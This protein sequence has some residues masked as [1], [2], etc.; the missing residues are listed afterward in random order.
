MAAAYWLAPDWLYDSNYIE[1]VNYRRWVNPMFLKAE[2]WGRPMRANPCI[3]EEGIRKGMTPWVNKVL[4]PWF[5]DRIHETMKDVAGK[6]RISL[7]NEDVTHA[8]FYKTIYD[9]TLK[10]WYE[11][12]V[13]ALKNNKPQSVPFVKEIPPRHANR[14]A[15]EQF[16]DERQ[17][18]D[19]PAP[20]QTRSDRVRHMSK[21]EKQLRREEKE[22][23]RMT[24]VKREH[25]IDKA[26]GPPPGSASRP[27]HW[28]QLDAQRYGEAFANYITDAMKA[29][30]ADDIDATMSDDEIVALLFRAWRGKGGALLAHGND[31]SKQSTRRAMHQFVPRIR[32]EVDKYRPEG[33]GREAAAAQESELEAQLAAAERWRAEEDARERARERRA[34][35]ERMREPEPEPDAAPLGM[36]K[37]Y[38]PPPAG[39][40]KFRQAQGA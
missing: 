9:K 2:D 33:P 18:S 20:S 3:M 30:L 37:P 36:E 17:Y 5:R 21:S 11:Q 28:K 8:L 16:G 7:A 24:V 35:E 34:Y 23:K 26:L 25:D 15:S 40:A 38:A 19:E 31:L 29:G 32:A 10:S 14:R 1:L 4:G 12:Q 6:G 27:T 39:G 13:G 22:R